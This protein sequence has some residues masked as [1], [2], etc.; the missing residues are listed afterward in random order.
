SQMTRR[1]ALL[2]GWA[3]VAGKRSAL[4]APAVPSK[5]VRWLGRER[6][7][8]LRG[9]ERAGP[10]AIAPWPVASSL[11]RPVVLVTEGPAALRGFPVY[12][13]GAQQGRLFTQ[14]LAALI[15]D[16]GSY[17]PHMLPFGTQVIKGCLPSPGVAFRLWAGARSVDVLLCF[18]CDQV[19]V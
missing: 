10:F 11:V 13:V 7:A 16:E 8:V 12:S 2:A 4:A 3:L 1:T 17:A 18:D 19:L 14:R 15:L 5:F 9:A 6:V